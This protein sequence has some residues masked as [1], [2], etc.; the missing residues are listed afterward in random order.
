MSRILVIDLETTGFLQSGGKIIEVGIVG[1]NLETG[2]KKILFNE[3]CHERPNYQQI[4][5]IMYRF[6][7]KK[8]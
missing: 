4:M 8:I 6:K 7:N 2:A 5:K 3:L 1:L